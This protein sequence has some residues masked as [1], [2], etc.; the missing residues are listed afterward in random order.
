ME[1][2]KR[3]RSRSGNCRH[4]PG[5]N[6]GQKRE[7]SVPHKWFCYTQKSI[8]TPPFLSS[9]CSCWQGVGATAP[10]V[11][12]HWF[13]MLLVSAEGVEDISSCCFYS[14]WKHHRYSD[15]AVLWNS[16]HWKVPLKSD[17]W[18]Q[19]NNLVK[20]FMSWAFYVWLV[21]NA[22]QGDVSLGQHGG[23]LG[24]GKGR[25]WGQQG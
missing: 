10:D 12:R 15:S 21:Y 20:N 17:S 22:F 7:R 11:W 25:F 9:L 5:Q 18:C 2:T 4:K 3:R 13:R 6:V 24:D 23:D 19:E 16:W 1:E 14:F 8:G